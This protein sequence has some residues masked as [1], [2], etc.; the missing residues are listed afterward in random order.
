[1]ITAE[2]PTKEHVNGEIELVGN[3]FAVVPVA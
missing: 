2:R 1:L 3:Q